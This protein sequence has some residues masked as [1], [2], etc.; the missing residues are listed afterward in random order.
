[1]QLAV[2]AAA[3]FGDR[4]VLE[5]VETRPG[6]SSSFSTANGSA[7]TT[8]SATTSLVPLARSKVTLYRPSRFPLPRQAL[9]HPDD[10]AAEIAGD[11]FRQL[12]IAATDVELLVGLAEDRQRVGSG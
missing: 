4:L 1:M 11:G 6:M 10:V 2:V 7:S 9:P 3:L 12:L 5:G 8:K